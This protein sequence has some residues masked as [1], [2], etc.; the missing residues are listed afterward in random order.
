MG[1]R[2]LDLLKQQA[3]ARLQQHRPINLGDQFLEQIARAPCRRHDQSTSGDFQNHERLQSCLV[4]NT[5][6][7]CKAK[8]VPNGRAAKKIDLTTMRVEMLGQ[9]ARVMVERSA[10]FRDW[11]ASFQL[12]DLRQA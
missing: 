2:D 8:R 12:R 10:K 9:I 1:R 7:R 11:Y 3:H 5:L 6:S 4:K